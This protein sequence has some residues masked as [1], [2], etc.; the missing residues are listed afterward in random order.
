MVASYRNIELIALERT[1]AINKMKACG[2]MAQ[3]REAACGGY[4]GG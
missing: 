4:V 3:R 2:V 1:K